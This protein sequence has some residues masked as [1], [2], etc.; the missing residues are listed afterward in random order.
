M[1]GERYS[2][3]VKT[4]GIVLILFQSIRTVNWKPPGNR[5]ETRANEKN[6]ALLYYDHRSLWNSISTS[7]VRQFPYL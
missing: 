4:R 5:P 7:P 3:T 6:V 1:L 2:T